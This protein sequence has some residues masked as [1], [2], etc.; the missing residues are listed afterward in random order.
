MNK[1]KVIC[2]LERARI[3]D[4]LNIKYNLR[5]LLKMKDK[6]FIHILTS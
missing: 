3:L 6:R 2:R 5:D 4:R 1:E